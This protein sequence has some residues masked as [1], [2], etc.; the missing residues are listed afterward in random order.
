MHRHRGPQREDRV[1]NCRTPQL[2]GQRRAAARPGRQVPPPPSSRPG[3]RFNCAQAAAVVLLTCMA[4]PAAGQVQVLFP[5]DYD[6]GQ[7]VTFTGGAAGGSYELRVSSP[8]ASGLVDAADA[9]LDVTFTSHTQFEIAPQYV[10]PGDF[11][12]FY[13]SGKTETRGAVYAVG[14]HHARQRNPGHR[15]R[16]RPVRPVRGRHLRGRSA[17][18][19]GRRRGGGDRPHDVFVLLGSGPAHEPGQAPDLGGGQLGRQHPLR[20]KGDQ[21]R[22]AGRPDDAPQQPRDGGCGRDRYV[23]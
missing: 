7:T 4:S 5:R 12:D 6:D 21:G 2:A 15:C 3:R 1:D 23:R 9:F 22:R 17:V 8:D 19:T 11:T 16:V 20:D 14:G 10:S 18:D 13:L